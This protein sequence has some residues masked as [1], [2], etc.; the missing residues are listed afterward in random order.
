MAPPVATGSVASATT[1]IAGFSPRMRSRPKFAG[2]C[3]PNCTAPDEQQ[4]VE[5]VLARATV[6]DVEIVA[7]AQRRDE[8]AREHAVVL[9]QH[10][11]RQVLRVGVDGVAEQHQ[12]HERDEDHRRE[13]DAVAPEL[14]QLLD[15]DAQMR[16]DEA[17]RAATPVI[18]APVMPKLSFDRLIRSMKTSS[19][20]GSSR[21]QC[22]RAALAQRRDRGLERRRRRGR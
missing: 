22:V 4:A 14:D 8:G 17:R 13:G 3:T 2:I 5:L 12:L 18:G 21:R 20:V 15:E 10:R 7:R 19:S 16:V 1:R 11:G 6:R 9:D